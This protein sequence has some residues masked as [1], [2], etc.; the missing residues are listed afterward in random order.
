[1]TTH[2]FTE[3]EL[4]TLQE[5]MNMA[6][7]TAAAQLA[8]VVDVF[9]QLRAPRISIVPVGE[10][11][12]YLAAEIPDFRQTSVVEQQYRGETNGMA[13][14]LF[15]EGAEKQMISF[16][17]V[18]PEVVT[19]PDIRLE[20]EKEVLVELGNVLIGATVGR[21]FE[22]L[23]RRI[24]YMPPRATGGYAFDDL[25]VRGAFQP[26]DFAITMKAEFAFEDRQVTGMLYLVNQQS[27]AADLKRALGEFWSQYE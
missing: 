4:D 24:N 17:E 26:D 11:S 19:T 9:I 16:F 15:P 8:E 6:F 20:L 7:G 21:L 5:I 10:L 1:M 12:T 13:L 3:M 25:L 18:D 14:L 22:L 2:P 27:A 23:K